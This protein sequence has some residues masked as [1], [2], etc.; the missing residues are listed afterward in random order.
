MDARDRPGGNDVVRLRIM[1]IGI[2]LAAA[3]KP[4]SKDS[5]DT[6]PDAPY[7]RLAFASGS[8]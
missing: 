8:I 5:G 4:H 2:G 6:S 7:G 3:H 1:Q